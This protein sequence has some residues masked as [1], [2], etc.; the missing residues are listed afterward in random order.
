[1]TIAPFSLWYRNWRCQDGS[2]SAVLVLVLALVMS[3]LDTLLNGIASVVT[4]DLLR[5]FPDRSAH[6]HFAG[7][8][9]L[10]SVVVGNP[11]DRHCAQGY[12]VLYL[13][14]LADLVCA[15]ALFPVL[16][17][18]YSRRLTGTIALASTLMGIG[19]G[20]LFFPEAGLCPLEWSALRRR[21]TGELCNPR[22][23]FDG[24]GPGGNC[25]RRP[26]RAYPSL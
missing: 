2:P 4:T 14:L 10:L 6:R 11:G 7:C 21:P 23:G 25:D 15:G 9:R 13:F 5:L 8:S 1:M 24:R 20:A 3:S 22:G 26:A 12:N 18:L 16:F 19:A 17:G